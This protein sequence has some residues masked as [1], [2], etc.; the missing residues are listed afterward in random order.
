MPT[1]I[2]VMVALWSVE[3]DRRI[4]RAGDDR[5]CRLAGVSISGEPARWRSPDES[6]IAPN[7]IHS[8]GPMSAESTNDAQVSVIIV[9]Y[10]MAREISRTLE[11]L[12]AQRGIEP[13]QIEVIVVDNGSPEPF[14]DR[15]LDGFA[16]ARSIRLDPAPPSPVGAV[17]AGLAAASADLIGVFIDGARMLSPGLVAGAIDASRLTRVPVVG[18]LA[19]HLGTTVQMEATKTGYDQ[20]VE[21]DLLDSVDWRRDGYRLFTISVLAASSSRGWFGPMGE[22]NSLFMRRSEWDRLGGYDEKFACPGGGLANHDLYR[23]ALELAD[24]ELVLLLGEGTFHQFHGGAATAGE[25]NRSMWDE[26]EQIRGHR[27]TPPDKPAT[28]LG[29]MPVHALPHLQ[30]S[31]DWLSARRR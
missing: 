21:D 22:C 20:H 11:T 23:R 18:A 1:N 30:V 13:D 5:P 26:Y 27:Y 8:A 2:A 9:F 12:R 16:N 6:P 19:F 14:D 10:D 24:T 28:L 7:S 4:A 29:R 31:L 15:L 25:S 17:N 3:V